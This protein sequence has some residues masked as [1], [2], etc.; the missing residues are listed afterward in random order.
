[1]NTNTYV[2]SFYPRETCTKDTD[3]DGKLNY[4]DVD[5]DGDGA[6][7]A[8]EAGAT[9]N[10]S[11]NYTFPGPYNSYGVPT[12][13]QTNAN[14]GT[15]NYNSTYNNYALNPAE[16][17]VLDS[18]GDG[19]INLFD[20]DDDNDGVLD[21]VERGCGISTVMSKAGVTVSVPATISYTFN[22]TNTVAN[23]VDGVDN[24]AFVFTSKSTST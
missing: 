8:F 6:S 14:S 12:A 18:D 23:L 17:L 19:I 24:N 7:D 5:S 15:V 13:V 16:N 11:T 10:R 3:G 20:L 1:M 9:T 4:L 22:G 2:T 21:T